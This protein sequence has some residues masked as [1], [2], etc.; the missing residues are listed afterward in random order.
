MEV[1]T[2]IR[3]NQPTSVE[4]GTN[5]TENQPTSME[6]GNYLRTSKR[7]NQHLIMEVGTTMTMASFYFEL[8]GL[9]I[10][11]AIACFDIKGNGLIRITA[12]KTEGV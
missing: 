3:E 5:F 11:Y 4:V 2:N 9:H 10:V 7:M 8:L 1:G 6:V 12:G